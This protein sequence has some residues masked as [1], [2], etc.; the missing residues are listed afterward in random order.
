MGLLAGPHHGGFPALLA[1]QEFKHR[2][3]HHRER[4]SI[5]VDAR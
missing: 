5:Q 3:C 4:N 1:V 2:A